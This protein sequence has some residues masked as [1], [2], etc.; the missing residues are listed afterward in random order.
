AYKSATA[1]A[2]EAADKICLDVCRQL[3][4][5]CDYAHLSEAM[6]WCRQQQAQIIQQDLQ[7]QCC[8]S[9][10]LPLAQLESGLSSLRK[11]RMID[12]KLDN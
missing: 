3:W 4:L 12:V 7:Q 8:L 1:A 5:Y 10:R 9:V 6:R 2:I 11:L